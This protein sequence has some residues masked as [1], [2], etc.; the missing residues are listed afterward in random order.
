MYNKCICLS[1]EHC[2]C[3]EDLYSHNDSMTIRQALCDI[4]GVVYLVCVIQDGIREPQISASVS[5][6]VQKYRR[7]S[8]HQKAG[9]ATQQCLRIDGHVF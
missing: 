9:L 6:S 8:A 4:I 3:I 5:M 7:G 1:D 2:R